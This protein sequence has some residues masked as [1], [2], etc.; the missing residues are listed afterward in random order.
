M[1]VTDMLVGWWGKISN[2]FLTLLTMLT[3]N[4]TLDFGLVSQR[5]KKVA[6]S[7]YRNPE[8]SN[9]NVTPAKFTAAQMISLTICSYFSRIR[10][11]CPHYLAYLRIP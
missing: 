1:L 4:R 8:Y 7:W 10:P 5:K 9:Q 2:A 11:F 6:P 3:K